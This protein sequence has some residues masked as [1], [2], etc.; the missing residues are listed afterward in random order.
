MTLDHVLEPQVSALKVLS[1]V[2]DEVAGVYRI[3][4]GREVFIPEHMVEVEVLD[5]EGNP[6]LEEVEG[7]APPKVKTAP[8]LMELAVI[9]LVEDKNYVFADDDGRWFDASGNRRSD[10]DVALEQ[11]QI[12]KD[13]IETAAAEAAIEPEPLRELPGVGE[14]L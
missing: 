6:E 9:G 5:A 2:H 14:E 8:Q 11:K 13:A 10:D 4:I 7:D 3:L 1:H 12:I